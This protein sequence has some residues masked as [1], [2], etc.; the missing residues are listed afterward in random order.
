[1]ALRSQPDYAAIKQSIDL[2]RNYSYIYN[3][4]EIKSLYSRTHFHKYSAQARGT[5]GDIIRHKSEGKALIVT[6][7]Y[8]DHVT[9]V[10]SVDVTNPIEWE[11]LKKD[12]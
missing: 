2:K 5:V 4:M 11:V 12:Y 10:R 9:A 6:G 7:I 1:M 3:V 8:G